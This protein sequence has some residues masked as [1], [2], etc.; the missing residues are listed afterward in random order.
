MDS[1]LITA[2]AEEPVSTAEAKLHLRVDGTAEDTLIAGLIE[3][4]RQ[5]VEAMTNRALCTQVWECRFD[6]FPSDGAFI[7]LPRAPLQSLQQVS[8]LDTT[9]TLVQVAVADFDVLAP[10][11]ASAQPGSIGPKPDKTWPTAVQDRAHAARIRF[12]AGYGAASAVPAAL[13]SAILL[14][15]GDL[16]ANREAQMTGTIVTENK[17]VLALLWPFRVFYV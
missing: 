9:G 15:V 5:Q 17:A 11:G 8:Y 6:A 2:P 1:F 7:E 16:Y 10:S 3:A 14:I 12:V 13:K 4:A